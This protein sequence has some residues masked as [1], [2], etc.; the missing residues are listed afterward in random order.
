MS[1][2]AATGN[3]DDLGLASAQFDRQRPIPTGLKAK[4]GDPSLISLSEGEMQRL[5]DIERSAHLALIAMGTI[6]MPTK[7]ITDAATA[8]ASALASPA[9]G[10]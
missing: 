7:S 5:I 4:S 9:L 8:L 6:T 2:Y 1:N 10:G 3:L